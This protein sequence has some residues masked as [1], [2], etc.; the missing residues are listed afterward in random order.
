ML[1]SRDITALAAEHAPV[2]AL[3]DNS[4]IVESYGGVTTPLTF[5]VA[6]SAYAEAYR[7]MGRAIGISKRQITL[8][9][10]LYEQMI[11]LIDGRVYYNLLNWYRLLMQTPGFRFNK[12]FMEQMMGVSDELPPGTLPPPMTAGRFARLRAATGLARVAGRL[13][14]KHLGHA[15]RV[16]EFHER[17]RRVLAPAPLDSYALDQLID[18][19]DRLQSEV[20]PAWETPLLN[21]LY[22]MSCHGLLR[23][24]CGAWLPSDL[25]DAHN[26]LVAGE[27]GIISL[28]PVR[29][30]R[31]MARVIGPDDAFADTLRSKGVQQIE[32]AMAER[33]AFEQAYRDYLR[34]FG[35]R[36]IDELKLESSVLTEDPLPLL[37]AIGDLHGVPGACGDDA[38]DQRHG[39]LEQAVHAAL[40]GQ[41]LRR[42]VFGVVLKLA[43]DRIRDREN[44][45]FER[46][47]VY[48]RVRAV[49][50]EIGQRLVDAG[51]LARQDDVFYLDVQE[52]RGFVRG[53]GAGGALGDIARV[54]RAEF[55][56]YRAQ[57]GPPRRFVTA[58]PPQLQASRQAPESVSG[59][60]SDHSRQGQACSPGVVRGRVRIVRDPR[61]AEIE[62]GDILVAER[63]DPGWVTIFPR[64]TGMIMERGSLLSHS[65]IVARELKL[66]CVVGVA[67]AC[68]W[69]ADGEWVEIDGARGVVRRLEAGDRAA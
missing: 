17:L 9:A 59:G 2:G 42:L 13:A 30:M 10:P 35:D 12:R 36:C 21:D 18:Y 55:D 41:P 32:A 62:R 29:R 47:R 63:T 40:A 38:D 46:T 43:R 28:E 6:R 52:I 15:R 11:G 66:P 8:N 60:D 1:Q 61:A 39:E 34:D 56:G 69:L 25:G 44:L 5:S 27:A 24:L 53:T 57:P 14:R 68:A 37:R 51:V 20:I 64:V 50:L 65:A 49:F 33:P 19:Y 22:C 48:G 23:K 45:R 67:D 54:R 3:W 26:E 4:N 58:G 31:A 16:A 7:H